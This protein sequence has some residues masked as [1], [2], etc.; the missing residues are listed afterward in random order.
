M[1][2]PSPITKVTKRRLR[3]CVGGIT[4]R[5]MPRKNWR[6]AACLQPDCMPAIADVGCAEKKPERL[7][8]YLLQPPGCIRKDTYRKCSL[9]HLSIG[10][11]LGKSGGRRRILGGNAHGEGLRPAVMNESDNV[12]QSFGQKR[13]KDLVFCRSARSGLPFLPPGWCLPWAGVLARRA[14]ASSKKCF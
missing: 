4:V 11:E 6:R 5:H 8:R 10:G 2:T 7:G 3:A 12:A 1:V 13:L 14:S 9:R